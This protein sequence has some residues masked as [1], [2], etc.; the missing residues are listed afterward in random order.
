MVPEPSFLDAFK[1]NPVFF[2]LALF[3]ASLGF[4]LGVLSLLLRQK[5]M[6]SLILSLAAI[7]MGLASGAAGAIGAAQLVSQAEA[8]IGTPGLS[9]NDRARLVDYARSSAVYP[10]ATGAVGAVPAMLLGGIAIIFR[11]RRPKGG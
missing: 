2:V 9:A 5:S 11:K 10:F 8:A 7:T 1:E 3:C 4:A 6:I